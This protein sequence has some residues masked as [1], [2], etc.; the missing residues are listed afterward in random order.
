MSE[1]K[2]SV[3]DRKGVCLPDGKKETMIKWI[4][5][6]KQ[7]KKVRID[8]EINLVPHEHGEWT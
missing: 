2:K 6:G 3:K 4:G 8:F 5:V 7:K 1:K